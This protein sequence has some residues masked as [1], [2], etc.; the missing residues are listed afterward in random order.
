MT[1]YCR[2]KRM[3]FEFG[4]LWF[5]SHRCWRFSLKSQHRLCCHAAL[6]I[7]LSWI[8]ERRTF[9]QYRSLQSIRFWINNQMSHHKMLIEANSDCETFFL[10]MLQNFCFYWDLSELHSLIRS[11]VFEFNIKTFANSQEHWSWN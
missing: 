11:I 7:G 10:F 6:H 2:E 9:S 1:K 5:S 3:N 4:S 8:V